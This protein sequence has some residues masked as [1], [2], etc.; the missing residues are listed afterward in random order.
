MNKRIE[1][2]ILPGYFKAVASRIKTF[3]I[4]KDDDDY[5]V[6]DLLVLR[7]WNGADYTG[8]WCT[9]EITYVLRNAKRFGLME[10]Y[11]ILAIQP[12]GWNERD[13]A[14]DEKEADA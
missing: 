11:C 7:E 2:K 13:A 5:Q 10:G 6:G 3:E 4:R 9:R 12:V 8:R 14:D 1:K